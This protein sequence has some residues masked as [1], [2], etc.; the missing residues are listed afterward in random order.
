MPVSKK[1]L[2]STTGQESPEPIDPYAE[3]DSASDETPENL[4]RP[5][6]PKQI[7]RSSEVQK[8]PQEVEASIEQELGDIEKELAQ[9][10]EKGRRTAVK[11]VPAKQEPA[12]KTQAVLPKSVVQDQI[13][14][15][16][17]EGLVELYQQ[18]DAEQQR[19][20]KEKGEETASKIAKLIASAK[21]TARK[22]ASLIIEWLKIIPGV[23]KFFLEQEAKIKAD[24]I[25]ALDK[26]DENLEE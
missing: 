21:A 10:E 13:E 2:Q 11:T 9:E 16:L 12:V 22:I 24:K 20:F 7:P 5:D 15:I 6:L 14:D 23:N 8:K 18:L 26:K 4:I 17:E 3:L 1:P 25:L 19:L